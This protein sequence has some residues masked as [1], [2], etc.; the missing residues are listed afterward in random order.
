MTGG[1]HAL[2]EQAHDPANVLVGE[3]DEH[4]AAE[5]HVGGCKRTCFVG[6]DEVRDL[7]LHAAVQSRVHPPSATLTPEVPV[8]QLRRKIPE[9]ALAVEPGAGAL[10][11]RG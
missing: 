6:V 5:Y 8:P 9:R 11:H 7:P 10:D 3:I 4:V 2:A 1:G